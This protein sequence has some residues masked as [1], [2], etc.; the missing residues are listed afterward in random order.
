VDV[1]YLA[2]T[3][4]MLRFFEA[5]GSVKKA[6]SVIKKRS[7]HHEETI[8]EYKINSQ[9]IQIGEPLREFQGVLTGVPSFVGKSDPILTSNAGLRPK[10][11]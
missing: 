7:G 10:L 9:G 5:L 8:R 2:D 11:S 1:S 6:I 3:V 4:V